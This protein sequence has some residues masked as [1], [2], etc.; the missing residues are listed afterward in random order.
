MATVLILFMEEKEKPAEAS[1]ADMLY[2]GIQITRPLLRHITNAV[3]VT[4][5]TFGVSVGERAVL[6]TLL[7][8]EGALTA[9]AITVRLDLKRQ[10][11][12]RVLASCKTAGFLESRENPA[13]MR[14][15]YYVLTQKGRDAIEAIRE[16]EV[17][18][19]E[20]L[21]QSLSEEEVRA[22]LKVQRALLARFSAMAQG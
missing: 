18:V 11:V 12:A 3:D 22:H 5:Q 17:S 4:S 2:E 16:A 6:E 9:P 7:N 14:S 1:L 15:H 8:S 19:L 13:H 10:F 21:L 20:D